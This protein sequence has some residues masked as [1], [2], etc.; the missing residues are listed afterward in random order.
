[1]PSQP[2]V[3]EAEAGPVP[4]TIPFASVEKW[5]WLMCGLLP[6]K[7]RTHVLVAVRGREFPE[8]RGIQ[9]HVKECSRRRAFV[10]FKDFHRTSLRPKVTLWISWVRGFSSG[11]K[12]E[13]IKD[14]EV[15]LRCV[16]L[17][18][19]TPKNPPL[20]FSKYLLYRMKV[21]ERAHI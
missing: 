6:I 8:S 16:G 19:S 4:I 9:T 12:R 10:E 2:E 7:D 13:I 15:R 3:N 21:F 20:I 5:V 14:G 11:L 17:I 1:M 18:A